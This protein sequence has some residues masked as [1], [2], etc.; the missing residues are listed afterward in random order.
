MSNAK[1]RERGEKTSKINDFRQLTNG[2]KLLVK[3]S[4]K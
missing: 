1:N 3:E 2:K 4:E